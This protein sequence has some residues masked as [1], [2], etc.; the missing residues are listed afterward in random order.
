MTRPLPAVPVTPET[1]LLQGGIDV[2]TPPSMVQPGTLRFAVN[3]E[4][5]IGGGYRRIGGIERFDGRPRP[6][7]A[8]Y[9]VLDCASDVTAVLLGD[10]LTGD[11]SAATGVVVYLSGPRIG[12]TKLAGVFTTEA[13]KVGATTVGTVV[14]TQP[15]VDGFLDNQ[16]S[17]LAANLYRLDIARVPG[18][19]R[20]R[21]L[22]VLG[23]DVY[24]WRNNF[25]G[26]AMAIYKASPA[27]WTAV[28]LHH[29]VSFT[30][31]TAEYAEGSTITQGGTTATVK[32]VVLESGAWGAG[33]AAG[34]L[35]VTAPVGTFSAGVSAGGGACTLSGPSAQITLAP[36]GVVRTDAY[37]FTAR[38]A[39]KRLYGCDGIN[40]EFE[41]GDDVLVPLNTGAGTLRATAVRCHKNHLFYGYR[42]SLQHS[43]TGLPY[44]WSAV[45]GAA[46]LGTGD[47]IA[48]LVSV[49]GSEAAAALMVLCRNALFALYGTDSTDWTLSPL[50]R[51][52]GCSPGSA[53]DIA[54]VIALDAPG[55][56]RYPATQSFGNFAWDT[57]SR[58]IEPIARGQT[59]ACSVYVTDRSLYRCFFEDGTAVTGFAAGKGRFHWT[60]IDYGR[61]IV[62]AIHAEVNDVE[63]TFYGDTDGYVYE[64]D[65]GRSF[66]GGTI[67]YGFRLNE[68][69][70]RSPMTLKQYRRAEFEVQAD[71]ALTLGVAADFFDSDDDIDPADPRTLPQPG[72]GLFYD[73]GNFDEAYWDAPGIN[74]QRFALEGQGTS[75][76]IYVSGSAANELPHVIR[77]VTTVYTPRRL[78]R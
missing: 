75:I 61:V 14:N 72:T 43:A 21:G 47:E 10:T 7:D 37:T 24:A 66:D 3:Y 20:I 50:S 11:T 56:V 28:V 51:V 46:E 5:A 40:P 62:A 53:Q 76:A 67:Q 32:R 57:A 69:S 58:A 77:S 23:A 54:G 71:S 16:L 44:V 8:A 9:I 64:A 74:R 41:F 1:V 52:S 42:G 68:L 35:I 31:G 17:A 45:F 4:P 22:G 33:T 13:V 39:D 25:A 65:V 12:L 78:S 2:V 49:S 70:Q 55:F 48:D 19:G 73:I 63:R 6:S 30:L 18:S 38:R 36:D 34:R 59:C 29:Q 60:T 15:D 27:G 26:T